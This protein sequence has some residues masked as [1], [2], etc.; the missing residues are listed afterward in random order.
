MFVSSNYVAFIIQEFVKGTSLQSFLSGALAVDIALGIQ[1]IFIC[2]LTIL[3]I[4]NHTKL[5]FSSTL[6]KR[7]TRRS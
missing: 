3:V 1:E 2:I 6:C 4:I 5:W 7:S